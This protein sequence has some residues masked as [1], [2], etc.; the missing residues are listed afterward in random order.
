MPKLSTPLT[1]KQIAEL[2]PKHVRQKRGDGRGHESDGDMIIETASK[3]MILSPVKVAALRAF[4]IASDG[5][6]DGE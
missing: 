4:L 5:G 2:E 6:N 1:G 3:H